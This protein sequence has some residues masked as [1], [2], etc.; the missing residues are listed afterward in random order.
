M[1]KS[2]FNL[3]YECT[4]NKMDIENFNFELPNE[5]VAQYPSEIRSHSRLLIH[6]YQNNNLCIN[7]KFYNLY[8]YI[9]ENDLLVFND[10]KVL[11]A[12]LYGNKDSGGAIEVLIERII[13]HK[14]ALVQIKAN[15]SPKVGQILN[16]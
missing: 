7:E 11:K 4:K 2:I 16:L 3:N 12:R 15:K 9:N 10:T 13:E 8:N 1:L 5:L 14:Q 6:N